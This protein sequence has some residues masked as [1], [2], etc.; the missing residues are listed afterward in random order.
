MTLISLILATAGWAG[1]IDLSTYGVIDVAYTMTTQGTV[2]CE[3][4]YVGTGAVKE[5]EG[6]RITFEGQWTVT[7][8]TCGGNT[9]WFPKDGAAFHTLRLTEDGKKM[10]E[11]KPTKESKGK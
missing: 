7:S 11:A 2:S 3:T 8:D 6:G 10:P 5:V 9:V 4:S 1:P